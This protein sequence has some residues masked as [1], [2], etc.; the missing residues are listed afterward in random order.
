[1]EIKNA[2]IEKVSIINNDHGMLSA[3]LH[4]VYGGSGQTFGGYA[5][6]QPYLHDKG[7]VAPNVAGLFIWRCMEI[8]EVTEWSMLQGKTIRV[9]A[10]HNGVEAIGHII[11]DVWFNP[12]EEILKLIDALNAL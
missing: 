9:K 5:L 11:K 1:M 8:G 10:A 6:F 4:L 7:V 12:G 2:S 3:Y